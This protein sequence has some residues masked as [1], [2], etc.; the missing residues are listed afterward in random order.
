YQI[1]Q[2][3]LPADVERRITI[4]CGSREKIEMLRERARLEAPYC[5]VAVR[6]GGPLDPVTGERDVR[7]L[8]DDHDVLISN[9]AVG[10]GVSLLQQVDRQLIIDDMRQMTG[11]DMLQS[12]AR[13]RRQR[14]TTVTLAM[15]RHQTS[16]ARPTDRWEIRASIE[17]RAR[18]TVSFA[19]PSWLDKLEENEASMQYAVEIERAENVA[20]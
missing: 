10:L 2:Q 18:Q 12:S 14:D 8:L 9:G 3:T 11:R 7:T 19:R 5:R 16:D 13:D 17:R 1:A 15:P 20:R 4:K 6:H